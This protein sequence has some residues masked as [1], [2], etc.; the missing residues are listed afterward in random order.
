MT[1]ASR[2]IGRDLARALAAAGA[3]VAVAA[4]SLEDADAVAK[5]IHHEGGQA[6]PV[7]MDLRSVGSIEDAV[8][9]V[10][11]EFG[12]LD[13]LV[14]N[15]GLGTNHDALDV[16]EDEWD[17]LMEVNLR[18]LFFACQAAGKR[19]VP[20]ATG[21]SST[22]ARRPVRSA[23]PAMRRTARA[24]AASTRSTRVLALE[25]GPHGVTV[26]SVA[27]T[28]IYTP[29]TAERLDDPDFLAGVVAPH[30]G[31]SRGYDHRRRRRRH[32]PRVGRA[33]GLVN[34]SVLTVDG[35][36]T[37]PV[38][39]ETAIASRLTEIIVDCH[40]LDLV[41]DFWSEVLGYERGRSGEGWLDIRARRV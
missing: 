21:A 26:N 30:P 40:D 13:I 27:P 15:A 6:H 8:S 41:A 9:E 39:K 2:G 38:A 22:S 19:M 31:R 34:G 28:F 12:S 33:A 32:L 24:R 4:R 7:A 1:G 23:S 20:R 10:E 5:Q 16:T 37:A 11:A 29:G 35:G 17:E 25:W 14:N 18:G 36:W 3:T